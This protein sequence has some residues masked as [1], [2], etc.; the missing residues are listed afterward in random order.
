MLKTLCFTTLLLALCG[1]MGGRLH[2]QEYSTEIVADSLTR[3]VQA[4]SEAI[5][6]G[7]YP[8]A[9]KLLRQALP[10]IRDKNARAMLLTNLG[11]V[12]QRLAQL[13]QAL[14]SYSAALALNEDLA[15]TRDSRAMI[16]AATGKMQQAV[17]D[18]SYLCQLYPLNEIYRYKRAM[19]YVSMKR[20]A[21]AEADLCS[22]LEHNTG[23]LKASEG[24]ALVYTL[25]G[26]Y[27]RAE[28][29]YNDLIEKLPG[30]SL[31]Y[32]GRARLF[33]LSGKPGFALRDIDKAFECTDQPSAALY[34]LRADI[35]QIIGDE[36]AAHA[37]RSMAERM[38]SAQ[39]RGDR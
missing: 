35:C 5:D 7:D 19:V 11:T 34:R 26:Q 33:L 27:D 9:E 17:L 15:S 21:E 39:I 8:E 18:Y 22:I 4:Q 14:L 24:L 25:T 6:R 20:Y 16:Y 29:L 36:K 37:D 31:G 3:L 1:L 10:L 38:T 32:E 30:Q 2:A 23:S 13:D 12:Y 28:R